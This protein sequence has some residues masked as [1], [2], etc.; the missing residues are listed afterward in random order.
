MTKQKINQKR[1]KKMRRKIKRKD[2]N[3]EKVLQ[4]ITIYEINLMKGKK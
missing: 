1:R 4:E 2:I 3:W